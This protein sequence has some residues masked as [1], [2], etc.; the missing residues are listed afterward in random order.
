MLFL[1]K[2]NRSS[3]LRDGIRCPF[4]REMGCLC[5]AHVVV[6]RTGRVCCEATYSMGPD[7]LEAIKEY[8]SRLPASMRDSVEAITDGE[9]EKLRRWF[10]GHCAR[11]LHVPTLPVQIGR[12]TTMGIHVRSNYKDRSTGCPQIVFSLMFNF[13]RYSCECVWSMQSKNILA[14]AAV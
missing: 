14:A 1:F 6:E 3:L 12:P 2:I 13:L 5:R 10:W 11:A 4:F 7:D 8:G 9:I